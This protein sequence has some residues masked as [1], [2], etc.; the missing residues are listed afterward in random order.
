MAEA[1][2]MVDFEQQVEHLGVN[3]KIDLRDSVGHSKVPAIMRTCDVGMIAYGRGLGEDNRPKRLF[4]YMAKAIAV[5]TP[6]CA[7]EIVRIIDAENVALTVDFE[8]PVEIA[9]AI[10]RVIAHPEQTRAIGARATVAFLERHKWDT[11]FDGL[12]EAMM[13]I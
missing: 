12:V 4:E 10:P 7:T 13:R 3:D 9:G 8:D 11:E 2:F 1:S 6:S 5:L